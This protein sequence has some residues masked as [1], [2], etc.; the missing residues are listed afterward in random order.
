MRRKFINTNS[1]IFIILIAIFTLTSYVCDQGVIRQEDNIRK[2]D[3]KIDN[4]TTKVYD[5]NTIS[6]QLLSLQDFITN[7]LVELNRDNLF[8]IK[9][10]ILLEKN[11]KV[12]DTK[13]IDNVIDYDYIIEKT[14]NRFIYHYSEIIYNSLEINTKLEYIHGWNESYFKDYYD[15]EGYYIAVILN[16]DFQS[17]FKNNI[18]SFHTKDFNKYFP[19]NTDK[20]LKEFNNLNFLD[21]YKFSHFL[22][23]NMESYYTIIGEEMQRIDSMSF[24]Y[25][26]K[27]YSELSINKM[28]SSLKNYLVLGSI[29]SQILSLFFLLLFFRNLLINKS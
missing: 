26:D 12:A 9:S 22:I 19:P 3:I 21:I 23:R 25:S 5:V 20:A 10:L 6:N 7:S 14:K 29:I 18:N 16:Y 8:W 27:L 1:L 15:S 24:E 11:S 2:S 13:M 17:I 4:L 28:V